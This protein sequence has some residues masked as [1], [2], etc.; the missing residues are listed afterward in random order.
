MSQTPTTLLNISIGGPLQLYVTPLTAAWGARFIRCTFQVTR[1]HVY[2]QIIQ[3][4][5]VSMHAW[6]TSIHGLIILVHSASA[7]IFLAHRLDGS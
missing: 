6:V 1:Y 5:G 2:C 4:T 7:T 3:E